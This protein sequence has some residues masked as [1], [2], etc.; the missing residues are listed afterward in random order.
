MAENKKSYLYSPHVVKIEKFVL[1]H[2]DTNEHFNPDSS[3]ASIAAY[4]I[5]L[6]VPVAGSIS[7]RDE[8]NRILALI[9][10]HNN[11]Y[12]EE[13]FNVTYEYLTANNQL[14]LIITNFN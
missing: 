8:R 4:N 2:V 6:N 7:L 3:L 12:M 1:K 10:E 5:T 13:T 11:P 9:N 14:H